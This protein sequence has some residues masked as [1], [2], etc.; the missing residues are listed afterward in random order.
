MSSPPTEQQQQAVLSTAAPTTAS[1]GEAA[2]VVAG[3]RSRQASGPSCK[4]R[5]CTF[6]IKFSA[7]ERQHCE[8]QQNFIHKIQQMSTSTELLQKSHDKL[9]LDNAALKQSA[10]RAY[11]EV[12]KAKSE[13]KELDE[14]K[15]QVARLEA[16]PASVAALEEEYL[17]GLQEWVSSHQNSVKLNALAVFHGT[18]PRAKHLWHVLHE[19]HKVT[20]FDLLQRAG[21]KRNL[22]YVRTQV[23]GEDDTILGFAAS[24]QERLGRDRLDVADGEG[25]HQ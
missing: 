25:G 7:G 10:D 17:S 8:L 22:L 13:A 14:L 23:R 18:K 16:S 9:K 19:V 6:E 12:A 20:V 5:T 15:L 1:C 2:K 11:K 24:P 4:R 21:M 3:R